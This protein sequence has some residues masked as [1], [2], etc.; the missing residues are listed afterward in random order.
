MG[1]FD[2]MEEVLSAE[3]IVDVLS[4]LGGDIAIG[5]GPEV[6]SQDGDLTRG[7]G[8]RAAVQAGEAAP[9]GTRKSWSC[10]SVRSERTCSHQR[11]KVLPQLDG[12]T[13]IRAVGDVAL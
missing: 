4:K 13:P 10:G 7:R 6:T 11:G 1:G 12:A 8:K 2:G 3:E 9:M 5:D